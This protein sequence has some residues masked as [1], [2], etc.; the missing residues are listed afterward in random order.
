MSRPPAEEHRRFE[1]FYRRKWH[2]HDGFWEERYPP[3]QIVYATTVYRRR[4]EEILDAAGPRPGAVLDL[5]C[6]VGDVTFLLS[7]RAERVVGADVAL[8]NVRRTRDNL[9]GRSVSN[10][11]VVQGGAERLPFAD[12][13]FSL[14]V[15]ADVIEHIPDVAGC[16]E[17][18][19]RVLEPGGRLIC[20][21][22]IRG[23]IRAWHLV[24]RLVRV[25]FRP[26]S[27]PRGA[28][29]N[30]EVFERFLT[31]GEVRAAL[32]ARGLRP[33]RTS[34]ICFYP[35]PET[36]GAF[37]ALLAWIHERVSPR[38]FARTSAG[39]IRTFDAIAAV[40]L[41]N[42]KQLWVAVR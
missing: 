35:A 22:P 14:V 8:E 13:S 26:R 24:D 31:R 4:N 17:E 15:L 16:L 42:Q 34:R 10:A 5:G 32:R 36:A 29:G 37:G 30:T 12:R 28:H 7:E 9:R 11:S 38:V 20:V 3:D 41:L 19:R 6:G 21:T 1:E 39:T 23:T 2:G 40:R 33:V 18:I 27:T 25:L